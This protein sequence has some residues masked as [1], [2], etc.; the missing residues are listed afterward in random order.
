MHRAVRRNHI[1]IGVVLSLVVAAFVVV[2]GPPAVSAQTVGDVEARDQLIANQEN[3][4]NSYRCLFEVDT[5]VVPGGCP[6]PDTV[7]PGVSPTNPTPQDIEVRDGLIQN[8]EALLNTYRCRFDVDTQIVPGGCIDG[9][10]AVVEESEPTA[11]PEQQFSPLGRPPGGL[12]LD[13]FYQKYLDAF[14]IPIV[15][16]AAVPDRAHYQARD[17][18]RDVLANRPDLLGALADTR[19]RVAIMAEDEVITDIPEFRWLYQ[20]SPGRDWDVITHGG[21]VGPNTAIPVLV[22]AVQNLICLDSDLAPH[23]DVLIHEIGH[24]VLTMAIEFKLKDDRFRRRVESAYANAL[25]AGLWKHTYAATNPDEYWAEGTTAWFDLNSPPNPL[26]NYVNTRAELIEYD[27]TLA[28]LLEEV[29]G[30]A[31]APSSCHQ[32]LDVTYNTVE[33]VVLGPDGEPIRRLLVWVGQ[34]SDPN[35]TWSV[36]GADGSFLARVPNGSYTINV[37]AEVSDECTLVGWYGPGGFTT[38]AA[39]IIPVE[40]EDQNIL[41]IEIKLPDDPENLPYIEQCASQAAQQS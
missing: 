34:E 12:R 14:G 1:V 22:V 21:G 11:E 17:V 38:N 2:V 5:E 23:A 28:G 41:G 16:S 15:S 36:T 26:R 27:P 24:A 32:T 20:L 31:S 25:A 9:V 10:P 30:D 4:L 37:Y 40:V 39:E 13:S 6:N 8:Q 29:Y 3:L 33:G 18:L 7:A 19:T 35:R